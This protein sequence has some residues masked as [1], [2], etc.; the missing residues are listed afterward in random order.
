MA[1]PSLFMVCYLKIGMVMYWWVRITLHLSK[2]VEGT[3]HRMSTNVKDGLV[4]NSVSV[5]SHR[6]YRILHT[7]ARC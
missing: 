3:A 6:L 7:N 4:N 1:P 5:L 2:A